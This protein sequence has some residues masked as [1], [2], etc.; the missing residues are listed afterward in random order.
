MTVQCPVNCHLAYQSLI[1]MSGHIFAIAVDVDP[2]A[3]VF[4][5]H[6]HQI[7]ERLTVS[8]IKHYKDNFLLAFFLK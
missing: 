3:I 1:S 2:P 5:G 8:I 4:M 6:S 7:G